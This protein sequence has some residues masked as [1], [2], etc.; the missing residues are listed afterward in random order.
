MGTEGVGLGRAQDYGENFQGYFNWSKNGPV[1]LIQIEDI[2]GIYNIDEILSVDGIDAIFIGPY[3]L[4][5]ES[6]ILGNFFI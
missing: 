2:E 3:D 5:C 6:C 1:V 4:S